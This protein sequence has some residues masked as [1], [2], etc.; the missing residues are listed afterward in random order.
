MNDTVQSITWR[1][2]KVPYTIRRHGKRIF[3]G[4]NV[5]P[6]G[7]VE[8]LAPPD[9]NRDAAEALV[10]EEAAWIVQRLEG[11]VRGYTAAPHEFL[12]GESVA[13]LGREYRLKVLPGQTGEMKLK[14]GC[15]EIPV[16]KETQQAVRAA[17]VSWFRAKAEG[18]LP[19][20][21]AAW[22]EVVG[23]PMPPVV[24][25]NQQKRLASCDREGTIHLNWRLIQVPDWMVDYVVVRQL[26]HLRHPR[27]GRAFW[28]AFERV[29]PDCR[30]HSEALRQEEPGLFW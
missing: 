12:T 11:V 28:Q 8:V 27:R 10:A 6:G 29:M 15:L 16:Q 19:Q 21:V 4:V 24:I 2:R 3:P 7:K 26:V 13:Y 23:G 30:F 1:G 14:H 5:L 9:F 17:L 22:H 25:A 18:R 20:R